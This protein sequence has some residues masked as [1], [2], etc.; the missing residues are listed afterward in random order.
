MFMHPDFEKAKGVVRRLADAGH[1]AL[2]AGGC[3]R[4]MLMGR[5]LKDFDIATSATP[6]QVE[7]LFEN[8]HAFGKSFG[9]IQVLIGETP[10]EV[11]TFRTDLAYTDGRH[12]DAVAFS[13]PEEDAQRRDFTVNGLF[14][15]PLADDVIDYVGGQEDLRRKII[16]AIGE[17][18]KRF[19]EDYL[20]MM[21]AARFASTL[22]FSIEEKTAAAIRELSPNI[23]KISAERIGQELTRLLTESPKAGHGIRLLHDLRLMEHVLPEILPMIGCE[24][25]PQFHPE[26][27]VF[28]HT[29]MML[30]A[31]QSPSPLLA[32]SLLLH[33]VGKPPTF[34]IT[35]EPDGSDRIRFNNHADVGARMA[36]VILRRLRM[37]NELIEGVVH[38]VANHMRFGEVSRMRES[39]LRK[40]I[41][42]PTFETELEL[43]RIDCISSHNETGNIKILTDFAEKVRNEP[44]LPKPW[45]SG[46]DL[47]ALGMEPGPEMGRWLRIAYDAQLENQ[48]PDRD[49]LLAWLQSE[50][51]RQS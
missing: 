30:D 11:A 21:R 50:I 17:P 16:R 6:D 19:G 15:D 13:T 4:D 44:V 43:H 2:F 24:Q 31:A 18:A 39:T 33:D 14:Y 5:A 10:F 25:P 36:E 42:A 47:I 45:L 12:P 49:A 9:V 51:R 22:E 1:R 8:T 23:L 3:V 41:A 38:C 20:R 27:D 40:L 35:R 29:M 46:R 28:V 34:A 48:Q 37:S 32:W 26:G 7:A